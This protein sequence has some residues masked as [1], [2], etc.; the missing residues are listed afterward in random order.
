MKKFLAIAL[1]IVLIIGCFAA[2]LATVSADTLDAYT[3][4][5]WNTF[6]RNFNHSKVYSRSITWT[7]SAMSN[8]LSST[9]EHFYYYTT[10]ADIDLKGSYFET[11]KVSLPKGTYNVSTTVRSDMTL[12]SL[13]F[14]D[15]EGNLVGTADTIDTATRTTT[16]TVTFA[17]DLTNATIRAIAQSSSTNGTRYRLGGSYI[18]FTATTTPEYTSRH[19]DASRAY[20]GATATTTGGT[21][22]TGTYATAEHENCSINTGSQHAAFGVRGLNVDDY[23]YFKFTDVPAGTYNITDYYYDVSSGAA[24]WDVYVGNSVETLTRVNGL[25]SCGSNSV[26]TLETENVTVDT[27]GILIYAVKF[28][29]G[30]ANDCRT[31]H[32]C[33]DLQQ[34]S[35]TGEPL[36]TTSTVTESETTTTTTKT[37]G[38]TTEKPAETYFTPAD[39][40]NNANW[41][42]GWWNNG[43]GSYNA[44][45]GN[46]SRAALAKK[47]EV[48]EGKTYKFAITGTEASGL[49]IVLRTYDANGAMKGTGT[50]SSWKYKVPSG[51]K[52]V[53]LTMYDKTNLIDYITAGTVS[54]SMT[55]EGTVEETTSETTS[56]SPTSSTTQKQEESSSQ[57]PAGSTVY[58]RQSTWVDGQKYL[59]I[60]PS[61]TA[62]GYGGKGILFTNGLVSSTYTGTNTVAS[63]KLT[64]YDN[65][66]VNTV[67]KGFNA[68]ESFTTEQDLSQYYFTAEK[69]DDYFAFKTTDGKYICAGKQDGKA[70]S[71]WNRT[72]FSDTLVDDALFTGEYREGKTGEYAGNGT[73]KVTSKSGYFFRVLNNGNIVC[74]ADGDNYQVFVGFYATGDVV[75]ETPDLELAMVAG[76]GARLASTNAISGIRFKAQVDAD[77]LEAYAQAGYEIALGTLIAPADYVGGDATKLTFD[78]QDVKYLDVQAV[79]GYYFDDQNGI[80][81]GSI[82]NIKDTNMGRAF[83][84]R[85][86]VTLTKDG[87]STTI[88][89]DVNDNARSAKTLANAIIDA[90]TYDNY[91]TEIQAI[92]DKWSKASD[93]A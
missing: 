50:L 57:A 25:T 30:T 66:S 11:S 49:N 85:A 4:D 58:N 92:L 80:I 22:A 56:T 5:S 23:V 62:E 15:S 12:I 33:F 24:K 37:T 69:H 36:E 65:K 18:K 16:G 20:A 67:S 28:T 54:A 3:G 26:K 43:D 72:Y 42:K 35:A 38:T 91:T 10:P 77:A 6:Y 53:S 64:D 83:V 8:S 52:Y 29:E 70:T 63:I 81:A 40:A 21:T 71:T 46:N 79:Y 51:V 89:A 39:V 76:A 41:V 32:C 90:G 9:G 48:T 93:W 84:G 19:F 44:S 2:G 17:T 68:I 74:K 59:L 88:Y 87:E 86:Y 82:V 45:Y 27:T 73:F 78:L 60:A 47:V 55:V 34:T 31:V 61:A 13:E 7:D 14:Y 75:E 1:S